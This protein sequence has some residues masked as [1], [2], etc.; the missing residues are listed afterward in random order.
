MILSSFL[1]Q[2]DNH[3]G[4]IGQMCRI[5]IIVCSTNNI[6]RQFFERSTPSKFCFGT[7]YQRFIF[8]HNVSLFLN[9]LKKCSF[10][11]TTYLNTL[12]LMLRKMKMTK[13]KKKKMMMMMM[14][15]RM[16][17]MM[18]RI[19]FL[20]V[21]SSHHKFFLN[22]CNRQTYSPTRHYTHGYRFTMKS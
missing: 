19:V 18:C 1:T 21:V 17:R 3:F 20:L 2:N 6:F 4:L 22:R 13:K 15:W 10:R 9:V 12:P 7:W 5:I 8:P 16:K 14:R 11:N